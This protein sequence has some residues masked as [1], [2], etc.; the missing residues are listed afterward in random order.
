[1]DVGIQTGG[2]EFGQHA[3]RR[4]AAD[5]PAPEAR[6]DIPQRIR[7]HV[8]LEVKVDIVERLGLLRSSGLEFRTRGR[9]DRL[10]YRSL[11]DVLEEVDHIVDHLVA[12]GLQ[13]GPV[14]RIEGLF[15]GGLHGGQSALT[16]SGLTVI[17]TWPP[18]HPSWSPEGPK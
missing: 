10:P 17:L 2:Q 12:E 6:M 9:A 15:P 16:L 14:R 13:R 7:R 5:H 18:C 1:M 3:D 8:G 11:P 4:A